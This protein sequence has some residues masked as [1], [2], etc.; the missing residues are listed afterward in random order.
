MKQ[1][2]FHIKAKEELRSFPE[3]VRKA[4]GKAIL[5]LQKGYNLSMPISKPMPTVA[6]GVEEIRIKDLTGIY[7]TLY[8]KKSSQGILIFHAFVK[9]SQKTTLH[10]I[11]LGRKRLQE[12][13][14]EKT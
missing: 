7:R 13:L 9:K 5:N 2:L 11:N 3:D 4:I 8:Y 14:Y 10:E 6:L 1:A 12:M